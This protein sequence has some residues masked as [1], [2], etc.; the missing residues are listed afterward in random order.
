MEQ[1]SNATI[2]NQILTNSYQ[3]FNGLLSTQQFDKAMLGMGQNY[4]NPADAF[5]Y[6]P[7]T[8]NETGNTIQVMDIA[9]RIVLS[10]K[11]TGSN[12]LFYLNT[13]V[14]TTGLY[15]YRILSTQGISELRRMEVVR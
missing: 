11:I 4:P 14:L 12:N 5:T 13:S 1:L 2:K 15:T 8:G 3:W 10:E 7:L 9:G 6:I